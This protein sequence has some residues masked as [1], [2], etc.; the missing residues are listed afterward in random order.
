MSQPFKVIL[1]FAGLIIT[2]IGGII[3]LWPVDYFAMNGI[4]IGG[5]STLLNEVRA[6]GG[7]L[8]AAGIV[9]IV[10]AFVP[11]LTFTSALTSVLVYLS[12][13]LSRILSMAVD[14][15]PITS[16]IIVAVLEITI[17]LICFFAFMKYG[18]TEGEYH[19]VS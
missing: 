13:G 8:L 4:D 16:L 10:G 5:N 3:L 12:Y 18:T 14:G 7:A 19:H 2:M 1:F 11:K 6:Q 15:L 9:V 17:G